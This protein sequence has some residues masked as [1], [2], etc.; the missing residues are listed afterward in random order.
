MVPGPR[1]A[2]SNPLTRRDPEL[3]K[4]LT[5]FR[6]RLG[7]LLFDKLE[8]ALGRPEFRGGRSLFDLDDLKAVLQVLRVLAKPS[9][10]ED[11]LDLFDENWRDAM[12]S[13]LFGAEF[14][15]SRFR[16]QNAVETARIQLLEEPAVIQSTLW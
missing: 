10:T 2:T 4:E 8:T 9:W 14:E 15:S 5:A 6:A 1:L 7:E 16:I 3:A 11:D 13:N 12:R